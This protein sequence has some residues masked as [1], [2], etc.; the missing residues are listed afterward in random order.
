NISCLVN[1]AGITS[2]KSAEENSVPEIKDIINTNL[3]GS[4]YA[5]KY[6]LPHMIENGG[7]TIINILSS[8][9]KS[10]FANSSAYTASKMGLLGYTNV[11]REELR[12]KNIKVVNVI[13]GATETAMWSMDIRK[14]KSER[15][16]SPEDIARVLVWIYLQKGNMVTEE[17][18]LKPITGDL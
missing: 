12:D 5:I 1:N 9:A 16:M 7:G 8:A 15:M 6:V 13:P 17:I 18:V 2:F 14:E 4:I 11:L 10:T 3:L